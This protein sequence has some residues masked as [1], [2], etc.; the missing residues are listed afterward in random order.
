MSI[1]GALVAAIFVTP[2]C[3]WLVCW[4]LIAAHLQ[5]HHPDFFEELERPN[6]FTNNTVTTRQNMKTFIFDHQ[7]AVMDDVLRRYLTIAKVSYVLSV[8]VLVL[9]G[10]AIAFAV[11]AVCAS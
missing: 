4:V 11:Y 1:S 3:A 10:C 2:A 5:R 7:H 9:L 6:L 8:A